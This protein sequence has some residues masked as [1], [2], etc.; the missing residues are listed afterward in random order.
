MS[1]G[2]GCMVATFVSSRTRLAL[3]F[4]GLVPRVILNKSPCPLLGLK[5]DKSF[6]FI[7]VSSQLSCA[8]NEIALENSV[9]LVSAW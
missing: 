7:P 1:L 5:I 4:L 8:N 9:S 6:T 2:Y 3:D